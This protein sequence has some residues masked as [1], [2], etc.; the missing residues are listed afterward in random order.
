MDVERREANFFTKQQ[1]DLQQ[2][3]GKAIAPSSLTNLLCGLS[4][5]E[6]TAFYRCDGFLKVNFQ[7]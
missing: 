3:W 7:R 1:G 2:I 5:G 6:I 4:E